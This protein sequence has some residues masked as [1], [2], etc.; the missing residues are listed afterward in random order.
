MNYK[1][2]L[3]IASVVVFASCEKDEIIDI[4]ALAITLPKI[5]EG[6]KE[7]G[8][9]DQDTPEQDQ[10]SSEETSNKLEDTSSD[11]Q[12][13]DESNNEGNTNSADNSV[14]ET[15]YQN[16]TSNQQ[17]S[18]FPYTSDINK[19]WRIGSNQS[20]EIIWPLNKSGK[21]PDNLFNLIES[22][23]PNQSCVVDYNKD[24]YL[25]VIGY[26]IDWANNISMHSTYTGYDRKK[27]VY[28]YLGTPEGTYVE[29]PINSKKFLGKVHGSKLIPGDFNN[30]DYVDLLFV[31]SGYDASPSL[32]EYPS[33]YIND[34]N[35]GFVVEELTNY[36]GYYH[37]AA[38]GDIDNNGYLDIVLLELRF[39]ADPL[40]LWNFGSK[41]TSEVLK[42]DRQ[43]NSDTYPPG[44]VIGSP[45]SR[46][47]LFDINK[48]GFLDIF[49]G[50]DRESWMGTNPSYIILGNGK[51]FEGRHKIEVPEFEDPNF[52]Q[53]SSSILVNAGNIPL[54]ILSRFP[55][56][57]D[58]RNALQILSLTGNKLSDVTSQYSDN[59][60]G[61]G[62]HIF[63]LDFK[64]YDN[65]G[66]FELTN[67]RVPPTFS[68]N[69]KSSLFLEWEY[70]NGYFFSKN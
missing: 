46:V 50:T 49:I 24:G 57:S 27:P 44:K 53:V 65:D 61:T 17:D 36:V 6:I 12:T 7:D 16:N 2:V 20:V 26:Y 58:K 59:N 55:G 43:F 4:E 54:L 68:D 69:P 56:Y 48:D 62:K 42:I 21:V 10:T 51:N 70:L 9:T 28:F 64:D 5:E 41:F 32:G 34:G 60:Y 13:Q 39:G 37:D 25:D 38:T 52:D 3:F 35:G 29:D 22:N 11:E 8:S 33:L 15:A 45:N 63:D 23:F 47:N 40:I 66:V 1:K 67:N 30:D 18:I 14:N 31:G 19:D